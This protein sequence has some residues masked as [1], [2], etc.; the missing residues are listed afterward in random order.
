LINILTIFST[1]GTL[2]L[3]KDLISS[4]ITIFQPLKF[5]VYVRVDYE[6]SINVKFIRV[7]EK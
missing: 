7:N 6:T 2:T 4:F 5:E 3:E 1:F